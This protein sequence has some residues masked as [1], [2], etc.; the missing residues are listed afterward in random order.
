MQSLHTM[1]G[2]KYHLLHREELF[3]ADD[4]ISRFTWFNL[5]IQSIEQ[6]FRAVL[7]LCSRCAKMCWLA[8]L[9]H[10][11]EDLNPPFYCREILSTAYK[12][13]KDLIVYTLFS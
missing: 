4:L 10:T 7:V 2:L 5:T 6:S 8:G 12:E 9:I 3:C 11:T 13:Y 1:M